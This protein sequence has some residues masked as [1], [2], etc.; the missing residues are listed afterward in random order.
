MSLSDEMTNVLNQVRWQLAA[1]T[2]S[3]DS[4]RSMA[5]HFA[6]G[7]LVRELLSDIPVRLVENAIKTAVDV[8]TTFLI[9]G[10]S[11]SAWVKI[12]TAKLA[13]KV[14]VEALTAKDMA[15]FGKNLMVLL[16]S[17]TAG[18]FLPTGIP[19]HPLS[20]FFSRSMIVGNTTQ[21]II[22]VLEGKSLA[23]WS[24]TEAR[25][26]PGASY[27]TDDTCC[28]G[29]GLWTIVYNASTRWVSGFCFG[30]IPCRV[31]AGRF[32]DYWYDVTLRD[33]TLHVKGRFPEGGQRTSGLQVLAAEFIAQS[34]YRYPLGERRR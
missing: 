10:V 32:R 18:Q 6:A 28:E 8:G 3:A 14:G 25:D 17:E 5:Y 13:V 11:F 24:W 30:R 12:F 29:R 7:P 20:T 2:G 22:K 1:E 26:R 15:D 33:Y 9:P 4:T 27:F 31:P 19:I 21:N 23:T 16:I 34:H